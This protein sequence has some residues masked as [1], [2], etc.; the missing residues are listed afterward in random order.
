MPRISQLAA[1]ASEGQ[2]AHTKCGNSHGCAHLYVSVHSNGVDRSRKD[3]R[4][5]MRL[6][7][8]GRTRAITGTQL[9]QM[10]NISH[11]DRYAGLSIMS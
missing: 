6:A 10:G 9:V 11:D 4:W 5:V 2:D 3:A 7:M 1:E 8:T